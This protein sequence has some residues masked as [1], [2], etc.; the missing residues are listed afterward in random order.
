M[1]I[2]DQSSRIMTPDDQSARIMMLD[3]KS[4]RIITLA[5]PFSANFRERLLPIEPAPP[6]MRMVLFL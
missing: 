1:I 6:V 3:D 2:R 4:S 5:A